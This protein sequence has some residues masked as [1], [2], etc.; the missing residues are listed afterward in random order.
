MSR[1]SAQRVWDALVRF[2]AAELG[3][4]IAKLNGER[5]S[6]SRPSARSRAANRLDVL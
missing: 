1:D 4:G 5:R 3:C 6:R 2:V